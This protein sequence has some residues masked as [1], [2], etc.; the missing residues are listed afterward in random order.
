MASPGT[1]FHLHRHLH[2]VMFYNIR[3]ELLKV[4]DRRFIMA[5]CLWLGWCRGPSEPP[6]SPSSI[7]H[8]NCPQIIYV[9]AILPEETSTA[10]ELAT[11]GLR[12]S[13]LC[14]ISPGLSLT[15]YRLALP[16]RL[17]I[18]SHL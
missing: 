14:I 4:G 13:I 17:P 1:L 12:G 2:L 11:Y 9:S 5:S 7:N 3:E 15:A 10:P 6:G 16:V 8:R 18:L